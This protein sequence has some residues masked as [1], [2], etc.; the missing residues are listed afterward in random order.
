MTQTTAWGRLNAFVAR[1][2]GD[3]RHSVRVTAAVAI[4]SI[5]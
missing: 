4:G 2:E 5:I 1:R 3:L